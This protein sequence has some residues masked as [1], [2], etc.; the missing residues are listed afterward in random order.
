MPSDPSGG[1][2]TEMPIPP[3]LNYD[4]C[5]STPYIYYTV[6]RV[7]S[8]TDI[9]SR[10]GWLRLRHNLAEYDYRL[11][12]HHID[13]AHWGMNTELT[14]PIEIEGSAEFPKTGLWNVHG[15]YEV[16]AKYPNGVMMLMSSKNPNG[17]KF[18]GSNGWIFVSRGNVGVTSSDPTSGGEQ[19]KAFYAK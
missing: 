2:T 1:I 13:I 7:H 9:E 18:E 5:G 17:I 16:K 3:N 10:P 8:Q 6:D 12:V 4:M 11:G 19:N 14:G 15:D